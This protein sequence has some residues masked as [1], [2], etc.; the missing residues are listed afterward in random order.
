MSL[1]CSH[2]ELPSIVDE[3]IA[4]LAW[5]QQA[6][7]ERFARPELE[8]YN[9][10]RR[11]LIEEARRKNIRTDVI[12]ILFRE[13]EKRDPLLQRDAP[14][15]PSPAQENETTQDP[16]PTKTN[17]PDLKKKK[18]RG[19]KKNDPGHGKNPPKRL[20][21]KK[22]QGN[23]TPNDFPSAI[24]VNVKFGESFGVGCLCPHCNEG[25]LE[26]TRNPNLLRF[27]TSKPIDAKVFVVERARCRTCSQEFEAPLPHAF[28]RNV[29]VSKT[30]PEAA[31][32]SILLRYGMG[33]P[34]LRLEELA[35]YQGVPFSNSRQWQITKEVFEELLPLYD[36]MELF[37]ANAD[38]RQVDDCNARIVSQS[39]KISHE[40]WLASELF[41]KETAVRTGVQI[42]VWVATKDGL[43]LRWFRV[44]R[45]HQG[46]REHEIEKRRTVDTPV[47]RATDAASKASA[48]KP[49][50]N[51]NASGF[52]PTGRTKIHDTLPSQT[53][54][55]YCWEHLR[56]TFEK[57]AP[58]FKKETEAWMT[59]IVQVFEID[60]KAVQMSSK[61]R[62]AHHQNQSAKIVEKMKKRALE[63]VSG[64]PKAEPNGDYAKALKY[65][66]NNFDGLTLFLKMPDVPLTT[67]QAES[68]AKF[69]KKHH[70]N[71]LSFQTQM[72]GDAGTFMMSIIATCLGQDINPLEYLTAVIEWRHQIT[73]QNAADW[74]P[75][76]FRHRLAEAEADFA[77]GEGALGYR[78]CK[79]RTKKQDSECQVPTK[80][81]PVTSEDSS[82]RPPNQSSVN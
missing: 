81:W 10:F 33:F 63:E 31:A 16:K 62:L 58:G 29:V 75:H 35:S 30:N 36:A 18:R 20:G 6:F 47:V 78:V 82:S 49:F 41:L 9:E 4:H 28:A 66:L 55:A 45:P 7:R 12:D 76:N 73:K 11:G 44:G 13:M 3:F 22:G 64:N 26:A 5:F 23:L 27:T 67:S 65:F 79:K 25:K 80:S 53:L 50:P 54:T 51:E 70:K 60:A 61:D 46:E 1:Q 2:S 71:S 17:E 24:R 38:L 8:T 72:G 42:T 68:G 52:V 40:L 37:V 15:E 39:V 74:F 59:D 43:D 14:H 34:D 57:A 77:A 32:L 48:I 69:T 19:K 21:R 56:Q